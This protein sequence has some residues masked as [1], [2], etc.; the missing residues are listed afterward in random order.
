MTPYA[1][2]L[3]ICIFLIGLAGAAQAQDETTRQVVDVEVLIYLIDVDE[4]DSVKQSFTGTVYSEFR[5]NDP[6]LAHPGPDSV[7]KDLDDIWYPRVQVLNQQRLVHTFPRTAEVR[8]NGDVIFRQRVWGDF[9]QSLDLREFPFDTQRLEIPLVNVKY[10]NRQIRYSVNPESGIGQHLKIPDW[11]VT[12]WNIA[13][14]ALPIGQQETEVQGVVF[15]LE[16]ERYTSYFMLK[17]ILPLMLIVAMSWMVFWIDP[18]LA[19]S[20]I[21]VGVTA[22]LTLIAYRFAIGG[23]VPRLGF[24]TALDYFVM[25]STVLVFVVLVE[26]VYTSRLFQAGEKEKARAV[27]RHARWIIPLIY[28]GIVIETLYLRLGM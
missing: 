15:T 2:L 11:K 24:L 5:W 14:T 25:L 10:G 26:V 20:Q 19:A 23:M 16:V 9:A 1:R 6:E 3:L 21:S 8:P 12:D 27:D 22:M 28:L 7:S 4:I 18:S 13:A 17:V